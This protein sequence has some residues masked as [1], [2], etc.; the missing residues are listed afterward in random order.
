MKLV[1]GLGNPGKEY[2]NT[3]HNIGFMIL[4]SFIENFSLENKFQ[5]MVKKV[6]IENEDVLF[7]KPITYMNLSGIS[8]KK[9]KDF[10]K[11]EGDKIIIIHDDIDTEVG[12]IRI[13]KTGGAGTHN[14]MKSI[15]QELGNKDFYRIK[16]GVRKATRRARFSRICFE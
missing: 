8:V 5:A 4:D 10:F 13:R 2:E 12:K 11:I 14:G 6:K 1:V 3:R 9:F 7:V 15:V 16:I